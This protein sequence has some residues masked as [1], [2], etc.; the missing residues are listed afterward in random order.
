MENVGVVTHVLVEVVKVGEEE[1][2]PREEM[3][4]GL[5]TECG[6]AAEDVV[7]TADKKYVIG[8]SQRGV[9]AEEVADGD[10]GGAP[11][12]RA[13]VFL[14]GEEGKLLV[15]EERRALVG[16]YD[17]DARHVCAEA[18]QKVFCQ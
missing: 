13:V 17:S 10:I 1:C 3:V 6:V 15:E 18:A 16:E 14:M 4:E 12:R 5:W 9:V 7:E 8:D 2:S 11:Q